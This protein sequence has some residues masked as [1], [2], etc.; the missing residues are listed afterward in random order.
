MEQPQT[1]T[2]ESS[3]TDLL[4]S[5]PPELLTPI[6]SF[7]GAG[8]FR[9]DL[10]RLAVCKKWY[11]LA[12]P[13]F[14]GELQLYS[15]DL[16]H[17]LR[18]TRRG[19]RLAAAQQMTKHV[20]L[21][22]LLSPSPFHLERLASRLTDFAALRALVI[23]SNF[24]SFPGTGTPRLRSRVFSSFAA[25]Q[26][27]TSLE[28]DIEG[29][30]LE[31][32]GA[33]LCD[34]ISR[35]IPTL[36]SLRCRLPRMC[37]SLLQSPPGDLEVFIICIC[38]S[39]PVLSTRNCS[40]DLRLDNDEHRATLEARL[41]QFAASMRNPKIVRLVY[42]FSDSLKIYAFDAIKERRLYLGLFLLGCLPA[43]DAHGELPPEDFE[44]IDVLDEDWQPVYN[45]DFQEFGRGY[46]SSTEEEDTEADDEFENS[47]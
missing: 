22:L 39:D 8:N 16:L 23:K 43:R 1:N 15:D 34:F 14:L 21:T 12:R 9:R 31:R 35:R 10:R 41:I 20:D 36:K 29:L 11:A 26:Q 28:I 3:S 5:L 46:A 13:V 44:E 27:L 24:F 38:A 40:T 18:A 7:V 17:M 30:H 33:H 37:N 42:R 32:D 6:F 2:A 19:P 47:P 4:L 45:P 25:I